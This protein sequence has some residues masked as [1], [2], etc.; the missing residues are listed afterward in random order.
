MVAEG[1]GGRDASPPLAPPHLQQSGEVTTW[2]L[3]LTSYSTEW[4]PHLS[5]LVE[6]V[7]MSGDGGGVRAGVRAG[8]ATCMLYSDMD[9]GKIPQPFAV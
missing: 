2:S 5:S 6:L 9:K 8:P 7:L 4:D 1:G 3:L